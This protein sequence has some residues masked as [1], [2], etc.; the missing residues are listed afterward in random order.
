MSR[1]LRLGFLTIFAAACAIAFTLL[2]L[3]TFSRPGLRVRIDLSQTGTGGLSERTVSAI[4]QLPEGCRLTAFLF[5]EDDSLR[6]YNSTVYEQAFHRVRSLVEDARVHSAGNLETLV[7]DLQSPMVAREREM[8]RSERK[9]G[10]AIILESGTQRRV[11]SFED[12]FQILRANFQDETPARIQRE[13]I[14]AALGDA[15]ISLVTGAT[16]K[17]GIVT[18]YGQAS[19][20]DPQGLM[21]L[22]QLLARENWEPLA[23]N[24]PAD[25]ADLDLLVF[26]DQKQPFLPTDLAAI[27]EWL[28][29]DKSVL[30]ALGPNAS[31]AAVNQWNELLA[32]RGTGFEPG[33]ICEPVRAAGTMIEGRAE[34]AKLEINAERFSGEHPITMP[35]V[36]NQRLLLI[37]GAR[38]VRFASGTNDYTQERLIRTDK[39]AWVDLPNPNGFLYAF[40]DKEERGIRAVAVA[41]ERWAPNAQGRHGRIVTLGSSASLGPGL[42]YNRDFVTSSLQWLAAADRHASGLIGLGERPFH[43]DRQ[44]LARINN[45]SIYG[46]PGVT[47][48]FGLWIFWRRKR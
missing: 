16:L 37:I 24:G 13:R 40:D 48:L 44:T 17:A 39:E 14:D 38:P 46:I 45:I 2:L 12:L 42:D 43:P 33:L 35:L 5:P 22:A 32:D 36:E 1:R 4:V 11:L 8:N 6:W 41:S 31:P 28:A 7:L 19:I 10:E 18:G 27:Q 30:L 26:V 3:Y 21:G 47:F 29:A 34:C 23:I 25:A 15:I 9:P 20:Q